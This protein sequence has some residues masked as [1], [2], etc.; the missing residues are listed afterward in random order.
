[1][2]RLFDSNI[3]SGILKE[4]WI[5]PRDRVDNIF[6]ANWF[7]HK[8][9][10]LFVRSVIIN[11]QFYTIRVSL[12]NIFIN[13]RTPSLVDQMTIAKLLHFFRFTVYGVE[14]N[15]SARNTKKAMYRPGG[16]NVWR[17]ASWE[18]DNLGTRRRCIVTHR[19]VGLYGVLS[20][21]QGSS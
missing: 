12:R 19:G 8:F 14:N 13:D 5:I 3:S 17:N 4:N 9:V 1:M 10:S 18:L 2:T 16:Q 6:F 21:V 15:G 20:P 11:F 7:S